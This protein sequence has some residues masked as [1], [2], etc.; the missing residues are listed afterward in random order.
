MKT[1]FVFPGQ[2]AQYIGMGK[3]FYDNFNVAKNVFDMADKELEMKI[4]DVCFNGPIE[5]LSLTEITQPAILTTSYAILK[6]LQEKGL[7]ADVTAGLSLGEYNALLYSGSLNFSDAVKLVKKRGKYMQEAVPEGRG[8]MA[9]LIGM[10]IEDV[11]KLICD[12]SND[13]VIEAANYNCP[14]QIVISG[15]KYVI[16]KAVELAKEYGAKK[17]VLLP[18]S[19]PFH[20]SL[21][22]PA[23]EKLKG[24]LE[25]IT[26]KKPNIDLISNVTA[27]VIKEE[28][29]KK[30]L[31][32]Q[33][34]NSVYWEQSIEKML[35]DGV[36]NFIEIGPGKSLSAF[37]KKTAKK[38]KINIDIQNIER[39][40]DLEKLSIK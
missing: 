1:A 2:G 18:V 17:A 11:N 23:G 40:S 32:K 39:V 8:K 3:E 9:A 13:G 33:V 21:L 30:L 38:H 7:K 12:L 5:E 34:Y 16:E 14:G 15:E 29:I 20:S 6:V 10:S 28:D 19:A 22:K 37:I 36:T 31:V 24:D 25:N 4:S 35:N 26:I 27:D